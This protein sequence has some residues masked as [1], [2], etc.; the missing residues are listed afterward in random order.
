MWAFSAFLFMSFRRKF[1]EWLIGQAAALGS[2]SV[3]IDDKNQKGWRP[4][5]GR[6]LDAL[7]DDTYQL[8]N[9]AV[10]AWRRNPL[11]KRSVDITNDYVIGD[12]LSLSSPVP[13]LDEFIGEFW[14]HR[15]NRIDLRLEAIGTEFVL[16]GDIFPSLHRNPVDG[17]SYLRFVIK[18]EIQEIV[19]AANDW[20]TE[21]TYIQS[22]PDMTSKPVLWHSVEHPRADSDQ[23][24]M[25]H[26]AVNKLLGAQA[27][28]SDLAT[29][30]PWLLRYSRM[31]EDR[32]RLHWAARSFLW[33][34][35]VGTNKVESTR[36]KYRDG[37]EPGTVIVKDDGEVWEMLTPSLRGTDAR[38]DIAA[39]RTMSRAGTG[40]PPQWMGEAGVSSLAEAKAMQ[41]PAERHLKRRQN[42]LV[43]TLSDL[44]YIAYH[45][46]P[47]HQKL[48][49]TDFTKLFTPNLPDVSR[50]DNH[51]L[52]QA[53]RQLSLAYRDLVLETEPKSR[54]LL[55]T[56]LNLIFR[57]AGEPQSQGTV[58]RIVDEIFS[59]AGR[60][61][62]AVSFRSSGS[63]RP[64][65]AAGDEKPA[66]NGQHGR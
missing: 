47:D 8:Y 25:S 28:V 17:M 49:T 31:L 52:A 65:Q 60:D 51:E 55:T 48:P 18:P 39:V 59:N 42:Y 44:V 20:E 21:I 11:A 6:Y 4:V 45:R 16:A 10:E 61:G 46:Q 50:I 43:Y 9:D 35:T 27:G 26:Y 13:Y 37:I 33:L 14:H 12:G 53:A 24:V 22:P 63:T 5:G 62:A 29:A 40:F 41:A 64:L 54:Q 15:K 66:T 1:A 19:T 7:V 23:A 30:I 36:E 2:I 3:S 32:V 56:F 58:G 57:G 34:V 38:H